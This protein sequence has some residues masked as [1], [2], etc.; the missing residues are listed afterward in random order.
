VNKP[1]RIRPPRAFYNHDQSI[2]PFTSDDA[3]F[4][5]SLKTM[6]KRNDEL[7][8]GFNNLLSTSSRNL[9][10]L[11]LTTQYMVIVDESNKL[12]QF[13]LTQLVRIS[14]PDDNMICIEYNSQS[15]VKYY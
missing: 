14:K 11:A 15:K 8:S 6:T 7:V 4:Y 13:D 10:Y 12:I 2:K 5:A 9:C 3:T 1:K